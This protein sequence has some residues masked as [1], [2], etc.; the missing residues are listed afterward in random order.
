M[1]CFGG[2]WVDVERALC[3]IGGLVQARLG[4]PDGAQLQVCFD[5]RG[6]K[7]DRAKRRSRGVFMTICSQKN[8]ACQKLYVSIGWQHLRG[9]GEACQ[10]FIRSSQLDQSDADVEMQFPA[11]RLEMKRM[12]ERRQRLGQTL[13]L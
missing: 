3:G 4:A 11:L 10:R 2:M 8:S 6:M 12:L 13:A 1:M 5:R 9:A 7:L